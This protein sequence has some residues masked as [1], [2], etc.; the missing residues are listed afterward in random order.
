MVCWCAMVKFLEVLNVP[1]GATMKWSISSLDLAP[2]KYGT[3]AHVER[4]ACQ[5]QCTSFWELWR[6]VK[7]AWCQ[8]KPKFI[9]EGYTGF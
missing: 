8:S 5:C 3:W 1:F 7:L 4:K 2:V 9:W 6:K